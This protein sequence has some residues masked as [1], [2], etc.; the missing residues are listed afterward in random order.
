METEP[1]A[2]RE[3]CPSKPGKFIPPRQGNFNIFAYDPS[4][5]VR[6]SVIIEG[7]AA[8]SLPFSAGGQLGIYAAEIRQ[9]GTLR[10]PI[11]TIRLV[12]MAR[13]TGRLIRFAIAISM[14]LL[15]LSLRLRVAV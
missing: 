6:G 2:Q 12:G 11:G 9:A 5:T 15:P 14:L 3:I 10:A 13:E 4:S 7:G 1:S 8:R